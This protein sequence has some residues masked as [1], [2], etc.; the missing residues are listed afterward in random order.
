[1][2]SS[3]QVRQMQIARMARQYYC[4][5]TDPGASTGAFGTKVRLLGEV[6]ADNKRQRPNVPV[7]IRGGRCDM[8]SRPAL[9]GSGPVACHE[10]PSPVSAGRRD[11]GMRRAAAGLIPHST[12]AGDPSRNAGSSRVGD[13]PRP[14]AVFARTRPPT[15]A[16]LRQ[17]SQGRRRKPLRDRPADTSIHPRAGLNQKTHTL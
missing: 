9:V 6:R 16:D 13:D 3:V 4:P 14:P 8:R 2:N 5:V 10:P 1:M 12:S 11:T 17:R 7:S 15:P